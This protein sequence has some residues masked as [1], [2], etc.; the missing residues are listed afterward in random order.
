M[1]ITSLKSV[2]GEWL[3]PATCSASLLM[4]AVQ[5][6]EVGEA[7][8]LFQRFHR[9]LTAETPLSDQEGSSLGKLVVLSGVREYPMRVKCATL[10]W[11][12]LRSAMNGGSGGTIS[13]E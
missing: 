2:S 6:L 3:E 7:E 10:A 8:E 9:M 12:T 5:G 11:H 13:T 1:F 4:E